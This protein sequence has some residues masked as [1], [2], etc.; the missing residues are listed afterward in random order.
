MPLNGISSDTSR[1]IRDF[2][3]SL[4]SYKGKITL[5]K[6]YLSTLTESTVRETEL[7]RKFNLLETAYASFSEINEQ[8]LEL[9]PTFSS[10]IITVTNDYEFCNIEIERWLGVARSLSS[11][12]RRQGQQ[13]LPSH[14][15]SLPA[16][17]HIPISNLA[18]P[19]MVLPKI[20]IP[21]FSGKLEEWKPFIE[22]FTSL[23]DD[24][25]CIPIIQKHYYLR[26]F[27]IDEAAQVIASVPI[28]ADGF[29]I[30][31]QL[32]K[33]RYDLPRLSL[34]THI[35]KL[36]NLE[37]VKYENPVALRHLVD[38]ANKHIRALEVGGQSV[39]HWDIILTYLISTKLDPKT[40]R[41]WEIEE[42]KNVVSSFSHMLEFL[43]NRC[44][45]LE[46]LP[47]HYQARSSSFTKKHS[48]SSRA[49]TVSVSETK[50]PNN[51]LT[52][53]SKCDVC[54]QRHNIYVCPSFKSKSVD[55]RR[56][57]AQK[58]K[59][60]FNCLSTLHQYTD[61]LSERRCLQ[62]NGKH[63]TLLHRGN[64]KKTQSST[65]NVPSGTHLDSE[66]SHSSER[67]EETV[68]VVNHNTTTSRGSQVLL[69]TVLVKVL[70]KDGK[71]MVARCLLDSA[72]TH[73]FVTSSFC[74]K[75]QLPK[76]RTNVTVKGI[77]NKSTAVVRYTK[78][79]LQDN[80][81]KQF[82][83]NLNCLV[84]D[85]ICAEVPSH[86]FPVTNWEVP[87]DIK[88]ADPFFNRSGSIDILMSA[89]IFWRVLLRNYRRISPG[90]FARNTRLG[91]IIT[92][93]MND[94]PIQREAAGYFVHTD[95]NLLKQMQDFWELEEEF[96]LE[97]TPLSPEDKAC[98]ELYCRTTTRDV[99]G[100]FIVTMPRSHN[101]IPIE[102]SKSVAIKRLY[103]I[104][105][106]FK[107]DLST[108][109]QYQDFMEEYEALDH[110]EVISSKLEN[111]RG[112]ETVYL[113]HHPVW[114]DKL[115]K[116][117]IR[118]VF[119][120]SFPDQNR[121][122]FNNTLLVGPSIQPELFEVITNFRLH[123]VAVTADI[124]KFYRQIL[125]SPEQQDLQR[126]LWRSE[127]TQPIKIF[128]LK[129][130][131]YG[132]KPS[133]FLA[134]R[135]L[136]EVSDQDGN[137]YC[138]AAAQAVK[139]NFYVDDYLQSFPTEE[140]G[141][142][143][144][145]DVIKLLRDGCFPL[146][147]FSSNSAEFMSAIDKSIQAVED[148]DLFKDDAIIKTLGLQWNVNVDTFT[149]SNKLPI[150]PP[151]TKR[152]VLSKIASIFDPMHFLSPVIVQAKM[153]MQKLWLLKIDWDQEVPQEFLRDWLSFESSL[154]DLSLISIPR[155]LCGKTVLMQP[156][157]HIFC[158]A[159]RNAY[160]CCAYLLNTTDQV[161]ESS[162]VC[163]KSK[164]SPLKQIT[165][166]RLE[167]CG[168]VLA[169]KLKAKLLNILQVSIRKTVFWTDSQALLAWLSK[170][171]YMWKTF[172]SHRVEKIHS[173]SSL[174]DWK[175]VP[176]SENPAD[177]VSR[178]NSPA[179]L[180]NST[181]YWNG[182]EWLKLSPDK[183]PSQ[184]AINLRHPILEERIPKAVVMMAM[185]K[186]EN[187]LY[188]RFSSFVLL[189]NVIAYILRWK[190]R[191]LNK[192]KH[193][194][195]Y[196]TLQECDEAKLKILLLV[197]QTYFSE[198]ID[199][200][201]KGEY[202]KKKSNIR[203]L[204]PFL[205][206]KSL[207]RVGGRLSNLPLPYP[208]QHPIILPY[209]S[210][211]T[212]LIVEQ[213]H[214]WNMHVG[215][216]TLLSLVRNHYWIINGPRLVRTIVRN[217]V[218][219]AKVTPKPLEQLM[220]D[221]PIARGTPQAPFNSTGIDYIGPM[222]INLSSG[223]KPTY[224]KTYAVLFVCIT[225]GAVHVELVLDLKTESFLAALD[226]FISRRNKPAHVFSDNGSYFVSSIGL[227]IVTKHHSEQWQAAIN[228]FAH[229]HG[230][231]WHFNPPYA[232]SMAGR[233]ESQVKILKRLLKAVVGRNI[234]RYEQ[235]NTL[236]IIAEGIMN[237][238][239]ISPLSE[240]S[241]DLIPLTPFHFLLGRSI[242]PFQAQMSLSSKLRLS[243][244]WKLLQSLQK[245][246]WK[247]W[248]IEYLT[249]LQKRNKW[250]TPKPNLQVGDLVMLKTTSPPLVWKMARVLQVHLGKDKLSRVVKLKTSAGEDV[251]HISHIAPLPLNVE[252]VEMCHSGIKS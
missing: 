115:R 58:T 62:C 102:N 133:S 6:N 52:N 130:L 121:I 8:L 136:R 163:S 60:C 22:L 180:A 220:G 82:K 68:H 40:L 85:Q 84:I 240:D 251:R 125:V 230:I 200:L 122:S 120:G 231:Y 76:S 199:T 167:L 110:M 140:E 129:T 224:G 132:L 193:E 14:L 250:F 96:H 50:K 12:E 217:C 247:R 226:R 123:K 45:A 212:T 7:L 238:R 142:L 72:A 94:V 138:H 227:N 171:G 244:S 26:S 64:I 28:T 99:S 56:L 74:E 34:L 73:C 225:T 47:K 211:I 139:N 66:N 161:T 153:F 104:E 170:P 172:V 48:S 190:N 239:P 61:C 21:K 43:H 79:N 75:L 189:T 232:S 70:T 105:A 187:E 159:S 155:K 160:G 241:N 23:I 249:L 166:P 15:P 236:L 196:L 78:L 135:T 218:T 111:D 117:K 106:R 42:S 194:T 185:R 4:A 108:K 88:L 162:L 113:S 63:H 221:L 16:E 233:W 35:K 128:R 177:I 69:S 114:K 30:S 214:K 168:A 33:E 145:N 24:N 219:C 116:N 2:K 234:L 59:R 152:N 77:N 38:Q 124:E 174:Q 146:H 53:I 141:L 92:G 37:P 216:T 206:G 32:L 49:H 157:L 41:S 201:R 210:R 87:S 202:V 191:A 245:Q 46:V 243:A 9:D 197:Q 71:H 13:T 144:V 147:K 213:I 97:K 127:P 86:S 67:K 182:P 19:R 65:N 91:W 31:L 17:E 237:S 134:L 44:L 229:K 223:K 90:V 25:T 57:H 54:N 11:P 137:K 10:D 228:K 203:K 183:W 103:S 195:S 83:L 100:R 27:I 149:Y 81:T 126:I 205:D 175:Y 109:S 176:T 51:P 207:L 20:E 3:A 181:L 248:T 101:Y 208:Q 186:D 252:D 89:D 80:Q 150:E 184:P 235:L 178:G 165:I 204:N 5:V 107:G 215:P 198:E 93:R 151:Y 95:F 131:T 143:V 148:P 98:E 209:K 169:V 158:D 55:E 1:S 119:N 173:L 222:T 29:A 242:I 112:Q 192:V 36:F 179:T 154:Q 164:I 18:P 156:D 188:N 246:L 118:I 39:Q